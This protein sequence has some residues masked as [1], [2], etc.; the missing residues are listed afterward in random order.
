QGLALA[1]VELVWC[2]IIHRS[3]YLFHQQ[4]AVHINIHVISTAATS[5]SCKMYMNINILH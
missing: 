5:S 1:V 3:T 4:H 2:N